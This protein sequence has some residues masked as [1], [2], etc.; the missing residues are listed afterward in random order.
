MTERKFTPPTSFPA[1]YVMGDGTRVTLL[2]KGVGDYPYCG[3]DKFKDWY[4][5][6]IGGHSKFWKH[7]DLHDLPETKVQW[8]NDF[9]HYGLGSW[10]GSREKAD[11]ASR[12][13]GRIAVIRREWTEGELPK[14]FVEEV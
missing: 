5:F 4:F 14:Y 12:T 6:S 7:Q 2:A 11:A 9:G 10:H 1:E 8:A 3:Q 13:R